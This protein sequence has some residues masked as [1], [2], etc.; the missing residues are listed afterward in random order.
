MKTKYVRFD[1]NPNIGVLGPSV[2]EFDDI[3][4][5]LADLQRRDIAHVT[6]YE[7][8]RVVEFVERPR[9]VELADQRA[10]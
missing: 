3:E 1:R 9:V 7:V 4:A 5:V 10:G 6:V 8:G 2:A